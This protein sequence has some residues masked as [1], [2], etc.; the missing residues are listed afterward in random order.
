MVKEADGDVVM[1][2]LGREHGRCRL[3]LNQLEKGKQ[4]HEQYRAQKSCTAEKSDHVN[5]ECVNV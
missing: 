2:R 4:E 5:D 1:V 3:D